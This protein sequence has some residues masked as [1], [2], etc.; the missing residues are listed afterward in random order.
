MFLIILLNIWIILVTTTLVII[1][2]KMIKNIPYYTWG[3]TI[4]MF[5]FAILAGIAWPLTLQVAFLVMMMC[6]IK[7][8]V[9][10][11][12]QSIKDIQK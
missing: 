4:F 11:L 10:I 9:I 1:W 7:D 6:A 12:R 5:S 8:I 3:E 2:F